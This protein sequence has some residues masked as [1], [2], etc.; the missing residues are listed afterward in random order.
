MNARTSPTG[1]FLQRAGTQHYQGENKR[2]ATID[3]GYE[4]GQWSP[5]ELLKIALAGC[6]A[7]SA[8]ARLAAALGDDFAMG[9]GIDGEYSKK[10]NRYESFIVELLPDFDDLSAEQVE[11]VIRR[12]LRAVQR[13]CTVGRT[14]NYEVPTETI[15]GKE[16]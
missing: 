5:G 13:Q 15:I 6:N 14:L 2:G 1:L 8:E 10:D 16:Q 7:L 4:P 11:S 9:V 3:V 12:A